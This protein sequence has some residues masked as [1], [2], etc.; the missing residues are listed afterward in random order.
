MSTC[1]ASMPGRGRSSFTAQ[2]LP[3]RATCLDKDLPLPHQTSYFYS[4]GEVTADGKR[5]ATV[6]VCDPPQRGKVLLVSFLWPE[7]GIESEK[8]RDSPLTINNGNNDYTP[9][10]CRRHFS[11][12]FTYIIPTEMQRNSKTLLL[13]FLSD[14]PL[15]SLKISSLLLGPVQDP[16]MF[17][18]RA[19]SI[20]LQGAKLP[21]TVELHTLLP[22]VVC[23]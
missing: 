10:L 5:E 8:E 18:S 4:L 9:I 22:S 7:N 13:L 16:P 19:S 1:Q 14:S 15:S 12:S 21:S 17:S 11:N 20:V 6:G 2:W 3:T 23:V